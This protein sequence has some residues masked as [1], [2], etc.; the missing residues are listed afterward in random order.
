MTQWYRTTLR[1]NHALERTAVSEL[2][3][4]RPRSASPVKA[5]VHFTLFLIVC[6]L[7]GFLAAGATCR[8]RSFVETGEVHSELRNLD[9][10]YVEAYGFPFGYWVS[11]DSYGEIASHQRRMLWSNFLTDA[12]LFSVAGVPLLGPVWVI[13]ILISRRRQ[14]SSHVSS[15]SNQVS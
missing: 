5:S 1:S 13:T 14:H 6:V 2:A 8:V 15:P 12:V 7:A 9:S 10:A 4:V 11:D 3:V